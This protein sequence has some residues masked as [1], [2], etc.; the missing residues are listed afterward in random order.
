M[1]NTRPDL[2]RF[3]VIGILREHYKDSSNQSL[4]KEADSEQCL[5]DPKSQ[6]GLDFLIHILYWIPTVAHEADFDGV[7]EIEANQMGPDHGHIVVDMAWKHVWN[8]VD[9]YHRN[10]H[11]DC[12]NHAYHEVQG[13]Y[14]HEVLKQRVQV[15][16]VRIKTY[17]AEH[18]V[19][20]ANK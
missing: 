17:A 10:R 7:V 9:F 16:N 15:W 5:K 20:N 14:P 4:H 19:T 6:R 12:A 8:L 3:R 1:S 18:E 2:L 13:E 11:H